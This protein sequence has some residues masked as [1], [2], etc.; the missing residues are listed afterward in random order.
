[1]H[2]VAKI[3]KN[4]FRGAY[5]PDPTYSSLSVFFF[6]PN[7]FASLNVVVVN[8]EQ[9]LDTLYTAGWISSTV[10]NTI[11]SA[12]VAWTYKIAKKGNTQL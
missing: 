3:D 2:L 7:L 5:P 1:M 10:L 11:I 12:N 8:V 6:T 9:I 4:L